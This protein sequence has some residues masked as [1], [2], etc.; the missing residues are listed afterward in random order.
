MADELS[1]MELKVLPVFALSEVGD[2]PLSAGGQAQHHVELAMRV[3]T[4]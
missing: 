4:G 3:G 2:R 1:W